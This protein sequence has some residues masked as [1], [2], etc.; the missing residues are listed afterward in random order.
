LIGPSAGFR[1][2]V[3]R[4]EAPCVCHGADRVHRRFRGLVFVKAGD[5]TCAAAVGVIA[6]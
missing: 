4:V 3:V 1:A 6:V 5:T 2:V